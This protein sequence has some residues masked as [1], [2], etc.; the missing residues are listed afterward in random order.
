MLKNTEIEPKTS[1]LLMKYEICF[2]EA[3]WQM[4]NAFLCKMFIKM[5]PQGHRCTAF[6]SICGGAQHK[7]SYYESLYISLTV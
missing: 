3:T 7:I 5:C 1:I 2:M 4:L 6:V